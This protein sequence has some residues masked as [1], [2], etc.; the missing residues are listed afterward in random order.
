MGVHALVFTHVFL[1][2]CGG[3]FVPEGH[4][5]VAQRFIAGTK[6]SGIP[7]TVP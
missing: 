6:V 3:H 7:S 1:A 5:M 2:M 4:L